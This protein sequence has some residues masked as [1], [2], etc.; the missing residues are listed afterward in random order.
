MQYGEAGTKAAQ[1]VGGHEVTAETRTFAPNPASLERVRAFPASESRRNTVA[2]T[3]G[4]GRI[5]NGE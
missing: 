4:R 3:S 2:K 1:D 5:L